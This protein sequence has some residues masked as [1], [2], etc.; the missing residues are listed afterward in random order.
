MRVL[1]LSSHQGGTVSVEQCP[2]CRL[3]WFDRFE[4]VH[5]DAGGWV[6]LLR[7]ME[8]TARRP[9]AEAQVDRPACPVCAAV[10]NTVH[11]RS[12]YGIFAALEC[13]HGHLHSHS[14]LLAERGLV[15]PLGLA[16]RRALAEEKLALHC[17]NCGGAAEAGHDV[18]RYCATPLVVL[19]LPRLAHSLRPAG[20]RMGDS[21]RALGHHVAWPCRGCGAPLD[22]GRETQC[23]RCGHLVVAQ[24]LPS[25]DPLLDAAEAALAGEAAARRPSARDAAARA[26]ALARPRRGGSA[27]PW[28]RRLM[29]QGWLPLLLLLSGAVLLATPAFWADAPWAPARTPLQALRE[30]RL[31][32]AP[33]SP[34]VWLQAYR[35]LKPAERE[36]HNALRSRLLEVFLRQQGDDALPPTLSVGQL[37]DGQMPRAR[38]GSTLG[39]DQYLARSLKP[40]QGPTEQ[41]LAEAAQAIGGRWTNAAASVW[42]QTEYGNHALWALTVE[43]TGPLGLP[44]KAWQIQLPAGGFDALRWDCKPVPGSEAWLPPGQ[45]LTLMCQTPYG[46]TGQEE[47]WRVAT[48]PLRSGAP[49]E[50]GWHDGDTPSA[51]LA[52]AA[53]RWADEAGARSPRLDAF[54]RRHTHLRDGV[55]PVA[56]TVGDAAEAPARLSAAQWWQQLPDGCRYPALLALALAA[57]VGFCALARWSGE[58]SARVGLGLVAVSLAWWFGRGEGAASVLLV[59]MYLAVSA[60][61]V[62]AFAFGYR[63]YRDLFFR[64]FG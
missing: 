18:C 14:G 61:A 39:W 45:R 59:G 41:P 50:L 36:G 20:E 16:E 23:A 54:L 24:D 38:S 28:L 37:L 30:E 13:R 15:R 26:R 19:D 33:A 9:L 56:G 47:R 52:A 60:L 4:S 44:A 51:G 5:L 11:N 21:P 2:D 7:E 57:F 10:L 62:F 58:R 46:P 32:P 49:L 42:V 64:P 48:F 43:N 6:R 17:L 3:V 53:N 1:R 22:P 35:Q 8:A 40:V 25:I 34:W 63:F 29:L 55:P 27:P 12:R 31:A